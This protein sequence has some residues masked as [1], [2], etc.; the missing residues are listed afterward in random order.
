MSPI[1][2]PAPEWFSTWFDSPYYHLLYSSRSY[3]EAG[4]FLD[5]LLAHLH[6]KAD[7]QLLDLACGRGRHAVQISARGYDVTGLDLSPENITAAQQHAHV[8]LRFYVHD[9]RVPLQ[10]GPFDFVLNLFTSFGYFQEE[11]ENVVA[12]RNTAGRQSGG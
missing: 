8:G 12:L 7:A 4:S 2:S 3:T 10:C 5:A 11:S 1:A 6:P 9:M